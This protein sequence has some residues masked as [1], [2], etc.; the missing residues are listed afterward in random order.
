[1]SELFESS[2]RLPLAAVPL[3]RWGESTGRLAEALDA[4]GEM[5]EG[6][7]ELR[8][9]LLKTIL[10]PLVIVLI[11][12]AILAVL[13]GLLLPLISMIQGLS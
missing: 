7:V 12:I 1:M 4:A 10:P 8:A 6:R 3:I 9:Q 2:S 11:G 5:Y 13:T